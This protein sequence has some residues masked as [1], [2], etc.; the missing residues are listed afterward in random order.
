MILY[1]EWIEQAACKGSTDEVFFAPEPEIE[2]TPSGGE[3]GRLRSETSQRDLTAKIRYCAECPVRLKCAGLGWSQEYGIYGGWSP[4]E[5]RMH[6]EGRYRPTQIRSAVS[7]SRD[8]AVKLVRDEGLSINDAAIK[9]EMSPTS[10]ADYLRQAWA[11]AVTES[12]IAPT[13]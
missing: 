4:L 10:V 2:G 6:D 3:L 7:A 11:L 9:M 13:A 12:N 5:R 1:L 8:K